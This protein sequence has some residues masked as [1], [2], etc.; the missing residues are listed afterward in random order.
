MSEELSRFLLEEILIFN[1]RMITVTAWA[2][3]T[4]RRPQAKPIWQLQA[5]ARVLSPDRPDS[6]PALGGRRWA[7]FSL[8]M[9]GSVLGRCAQPTLVPLLTFFFKKTIVFYQSREDRKTSS[10]LRNMLVW[11]VLQVWTFV[12]PKASAVAGTFSVCKCARGRMVNTL[13]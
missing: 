1:Q 2:E 4:D 6:G 8:Q 12:T 5:R 11:G 10:S 13:T 3:D 7:P 9:Q